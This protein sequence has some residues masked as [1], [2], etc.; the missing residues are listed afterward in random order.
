MLPRKERKNTL[1]ES[2]ASLNRAG[3]GLY[4]FQ[5]PYEDDRFE[6]IPPVLCVADNR[7]IQ[8]CREIDG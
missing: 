2:R 5:F 7:N 8:N 1:H 3:H 6:G 4:M